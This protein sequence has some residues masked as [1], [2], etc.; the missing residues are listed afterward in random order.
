MKNDTTTAPPQPHVDNNLIYQYLLKAYNSSLFSF[1]FSLL[2]QLYRYPTSRDCQSNYRPISIFLLEY[3]V[4]SSFT[5][6]SYFFLPKFSN[7]F[8][9]DPIPSEFQS[10]SKT[11]HPSLDLPTTWSSR[12][13]KKK[14]KR[15]KQNPKKPQ[16]DEIAKNRIV[17]CRLKEQSMVMKNT[18]S[19]FLTP[20]TSS[21]PSHFPF[22]HRFSLLPSSSSLSLSEKSEIT[23]PKNGVRPM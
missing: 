22:L 23:K 8:W 5:H 4:V 2:I 19:I 1:L 16:R 12:K 13:K 9:S 3:L 20:V 7:S 10:W 17:E 21:S 14:K 15:R 18:T 6:S 11:A